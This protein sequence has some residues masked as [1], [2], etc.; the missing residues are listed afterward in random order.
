MRSV[1]LV[2]VLFRLI[3]KTRLE[4][5][6]GLVTCL[7]VTSCTILSSDS[8]RLMDCLVDAIS[9]HVS[10]NTVEIRTR[11][12]TKDCYMSINMDVEPSQ[13]EMLLE[14][15][16]AACDWSTT[17][18]TPNSP[19]ASISVRNLCASLLF[20]KIHHLHYHMPAP[21]FSDADRD[22]LGLLL[23]QE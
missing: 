1:C 15:R 17:L 16:N 4:V 14:S 21:V 22:Y 19:T 12:M 7:Q 20:G 23:D 2:E 10:L 13:G 6:T 11:S 8:M 18:S 9:P 5:A 3:N